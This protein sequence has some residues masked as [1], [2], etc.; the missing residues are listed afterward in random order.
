MVGDIA[1]SI[2]QLNAELVPQ[3]CWDFSY[4]DQIREALFEHMLDGSDD[5]SFPLKPQRVVTDVRNAVSDCG[6]I[7]LDNGM[8]KIWFARN[9][10]AFCP[11]T[12]L[13]DNALA[14]MGAGLPSAIAAK[15][16]RPNLD[17]TAICGDGGFMMNSQELETAKRLG[18][19]LVVLVLNDNGF[20]MIKWKQANMGFDDWGLEFG[21]PDF[22]KY[23]ESYGAVGHRI[24]GADT[25]EPLMKRC[26]AD[27][28]LHLIEVPIDY[29]D[30]DRILNHEIKSLS[31][32]L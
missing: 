24:A 31:S 10:R 15:L 23:A 25:L 9:Y 7:A 18:L 3:E 14:T 1:N 20:G 29:S 32:K 5:C 28:G 12:V 13:L 21:N 30:S 11:N 19:D 22:V 17:V 16:V 8:Y 27:G 26:H 6:I 4:F 2:W